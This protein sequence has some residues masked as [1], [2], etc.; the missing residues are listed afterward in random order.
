[1]PNK[2]NILPVQKIY[3]FIKPPNGFL[4]YI[5][6]TAVIRFSLCSADSGFNRVEPKDYKPRLLKFDDKVSFLIIIIS[7]WSF[8]VENLYSV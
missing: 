6:V 1:M 2:N 8:S 4:R 3:L 5:N 7:S